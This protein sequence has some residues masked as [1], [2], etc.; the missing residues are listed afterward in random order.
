MRESFQS[1]QCVTAKSRHLSF[2]WHCQDHVSAN[3]ILFHKP[4][5][6]AEAQNC[7]EMAASYLGILESLP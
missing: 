3:A 4:C 5:G 1:Y 2:Y 6:V 7:C